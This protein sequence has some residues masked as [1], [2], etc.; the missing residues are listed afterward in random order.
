MV[1]QTVAPACSRRTGSAAGSAS[2]WS[3]SGSPSRRAEPNRDAWVRGLTGPRHISRTPRA[4]RGEKPR[5]T[6]RGGD[7]RTPSEDPGST[8]DRTPGATAWSGPPTCR[9]TDTA[10]PDRCA[11]LV[12]PRRVVRRCGS[13]TTGRR[14]SGPAQRRQDLDRPRNSRRRR[15]SS[16]VESSHRLRPTAP[17]EPATT[18]QRAPRRTT[19]ATV[20]VRSADT[21]PTG[22]ITHGA[23]P[24]PGADA[25]RARTGGGG[26]GSHR[27]GLP[28]SPGGD[29]VPAPPMQGRE[30]MSD[31]HGAIVPT[32]RTSG[33]LSGHRLRGARFGGGY[34]GP[35]DRRACRDDCDSSQR[36]DRSAGS[37][38]PDSEASQAGSGGHSLEMSSTSPSGSTTSIRRC[39]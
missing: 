39:P 26:G 25:A 4:P 7:G 37:T 20:R 29:R 32:P 6:S 19:T 15:R 9:L 34:R 5:E 2:R 31:R 14:S 12:G 24:Q 16:A 8:S 27:R 36:S 10:P 35:R 28:S 18:T 3:T 17:T 38:Q 30:P 11:Q 33:L 23:G 22:G 13:G 1:G 21:T